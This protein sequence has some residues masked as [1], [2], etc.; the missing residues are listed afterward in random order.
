MPQN[1]SELDEWQRIFN[2][3]PTYERKEDMVRKFMIMTAKRRA[4]R[5]MSILKSSKHGLTY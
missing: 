3:K 4:Q 2:K 5:R 1:K